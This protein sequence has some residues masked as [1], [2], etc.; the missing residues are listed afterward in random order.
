[1]IT[2]A[3]AAYPLDWFEDWAGYAAKMDAWVTRAAEDG[4][5]ILLFP[6]YGAMELASLS[7]VDPADLRAATRAVADHMPR[8]VAHLSDL[9]QRHGVHIVA[10]S[11][12]VIDG[13]TLV[14][15][16]HML[17]P[18]GRILHQDKQIMTPWEVA[19][20]GVSGHGPL[21]IFDTE[22]GRIGILICYDCEFP[23]LARQLTDAGC[24]V[25]LIPSA[26]ETLGG[27][28]RVRIGAMARALEGQCYTA[29][30]SIIGT[31]PI[32][33]VD[34]SHGAGGIYCPPDIGLPQDGI[35]A[36]GALDD[37]GWTIAQIDLDHLAHIRA[38]GGV[39]NRADWPLQLGRETRETP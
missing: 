15:R 18:D 14:N 25:I 10:P 1:M 12:P 31:Y 24:D 22:H 33:A 35:V 8:A 37:A 38:Q 7:N 28:W 39:R 19:P 11:G 29:M 2:L 3:A 26:T 6:E 30:A 21:Q 27:Y 13:D 16:A 20:W 23:L 36:Q 17:F 5:Q 9:A 34:V 32:E 4:A